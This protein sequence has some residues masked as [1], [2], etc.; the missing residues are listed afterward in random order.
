MKIL[1]I[2]DNADNLTALR[3]VLSDTLPE[4]TLLCALD[5]LQ[6]LAMAS[7]TDPDVILLDIVMPDVDGFAVC[8]NL[9]QNLALQVIPVVFMTAV[10]TDQESRLMALEVGAEGFL[11]KPFDPIELVA[12]IHTMAKI[13]AATAAQVDVN[14]RL[15]DLVEERTAALRQNHTATL[16]LLE[17]LQAENAARKASEEAL[18]ESGRRHQAI[19]QAAMDGFWLVDAEGRLLEVNDAYCR[20]SGYP[21]EE[22]LGMHA[23]ELQVDAAD[24]EIAARI[25]QF[26]TRGEERFESHHRRKDGSAFDVEVSIQC[27]PGD[28]LPVVIFL[29]DITEH[30]QAEI[31]QEMRRQILQILNESG[32]LQDALQR[33]IGVIQSHTGC[34][35]VAIR[36]QD[37]EDFPYFAHCGFGDDFLSEENSLVLHDT[38]GKLCRDENGHLRLACACGLVLAGKTTPA[39]PYF[40]SGG[41]FWTNDLSTLAK[42]S[43]SRLPQIFSRNRC[44]QHGDAS[45]AL[46]PIRNQ[47]RIVGLIQLNDRHKG[48][49]TSQT[50]EILESIASHLG[51]ALMRKHA[52]AQLIETN[53]HLEAATARANE[54]AAQAE[55]ANAAKSAFLANMSHE[56]RTP[57]NG[58]IGLTGLLLDTELSAEQLRYAHTIRSSGEILLG[59]INDFLD[60]SKIEAESAGGLRPDPRRAG[61]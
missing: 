5:G 53:R 28:G 29:R 49:F 26:K 61:A 46:I 50:V 36:L 8:R 9:K 48:R 35:A 52:E 15:A 4:A 58:V 18:R 31:Y 30:K 3:A 27:R 23:A 22:L 40:T 44:L 19:L 33:I 59:L 55:M 11:S 13:K 14:V 7:G 51:S 43:P 6:G 24:D 10:K 12:T 17:D 54:M 47:Q 42:S 2:D 41:G 20:M 16:N 21:R 39:R 25:Q 1:A 32:D 34:A 57:L 60:I 45:L 37:G 56:I 38:T